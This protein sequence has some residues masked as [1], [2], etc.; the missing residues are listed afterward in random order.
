MAREFSRTRRIGEQ[1]KRD[2]AGLIRSEV[3]DPRM[4]MV[5]ITSVT[6]SRDLGVAQIYVTLLGDPQERES[7]IETLNRSTPMLR[8]LLGK[9]M[10]IRNVPSLVFHYDDVVERG[11]EL[12]DLITRTVAAD[13][14]RADSA[15]HQEAD[16][17]KDPGD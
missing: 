7:V 14:A 1:I 12:S 9:I 15:R 11:A 6:V 16:D 10:R 4:L 8:R 17:K 3:D 13:A 5:S 2:L